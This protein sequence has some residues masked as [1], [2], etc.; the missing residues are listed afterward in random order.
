[1]LPQNSKIKHFRIKL[2][3]QTE[4]EEKNSQEL[5]KKAKRESYKN[6]RSIQKKQITGIKNKIS[7]NLAN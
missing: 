7:G 1:M 5:T 2:Q 6:L 4:L 3:Q